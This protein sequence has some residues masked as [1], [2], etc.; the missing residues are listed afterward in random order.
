MTTARGGNDGLKVEVCRRGDT[1]C[2]FMGIG[3]CFMDL[4]LIFAFVF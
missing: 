1:G 3:L 4:N 2:D